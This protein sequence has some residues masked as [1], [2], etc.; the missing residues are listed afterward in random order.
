MEFRFNHQPPVKRDVFADF[1]DD[2]E[3]VFVL[4]FSLAVDADRGVVEHEI[5]GYAHPG[6]D[7]PGVVFIDQRDGKIALVGAGIGSGSSRWVDRH[8][9]RKTDIAVIKSGFDTAMAGD[10]RFKRQSEIDRE[11]FRVTAAV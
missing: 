4:L 11:A 2:P 9:G 1:G 6:I 8:S 5:V 10:A 3:P 7:D